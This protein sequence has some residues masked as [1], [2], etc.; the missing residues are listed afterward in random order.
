MHF[1]VKGCPTKEG[2][3]DEIGEWSSS[4]VAPT[5]DE[6]GAFSW[7]ARKSTPYGHGPL[8]AELHNICDGLQKCPIGRL[9]SMGIPICRVRGGQRTTARTIN[10]TPCVAGL[11]FADVFQ[12]HLHFRTQ[13]SR[14]FSV[15]TN[16]ASFKVIPLSHRRQH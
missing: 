14:K 16:S 6:Q 11:P 12:A 2:L 13:Y 7:R 15:L 4:W 10:L 5:V 9:I 3:A 1:R 8:M